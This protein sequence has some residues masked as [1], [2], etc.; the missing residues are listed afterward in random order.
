M[1]DHITDY[2]RSKA[3]DLPTPLTK[4]LPT[5]HLIQQLDQVTI[6]AINGRATWADV[7]KAF[8]AVLSHPQNTFTRELL[9]YRQRITHN[10]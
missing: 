10:S 4:P 7:D 1:T 6:E 8:D 2:Y 5:A 9:D 3:R